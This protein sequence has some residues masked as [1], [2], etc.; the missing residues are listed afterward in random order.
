MKFWEHFNIERLFKSGM[1][2]VQLN[3]AMSKL[4]RGFDTMETT[5][6]SA[7]YN[8][9]QHK[10]QYAHVKVKSGVRQM[11]AALKSAECQLKTYEADNKKMSTMT[12]FE[13][14]DLK[15]TSKTKRRSDY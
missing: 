5:I 6:Q 7:M 3:E 14:I 15:K 2:Y 1:N 8:I 10:L 12:N 13:I 9:A 4:Q 11:K